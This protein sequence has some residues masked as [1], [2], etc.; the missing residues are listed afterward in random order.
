MQP[1]LHV[2]SGDTVLILSGNDKGKQGVVKQ[3]FPREGKIVVEG[4]N[5]RWRHQ[6][7][8]QQR[9]K[10][11]RVQREVPLFACKVK[12]VSSGKRK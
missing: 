12:L 6:K 4:V 5:L 8:S 3:A 9:P 11:D 1:K 2:K 10:G 7:P